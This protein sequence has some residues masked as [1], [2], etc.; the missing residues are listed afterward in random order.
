MKDIY[1]RIEYNDSPLPITC[2]HEDKKSSTLRLHYS[3]R[4]KLLCISIS[5]Y[6]TI[7]I[8]IVTVYSKTAEKFS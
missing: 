3:M 4:T 1:S 8:R 6:H 2:V 5:Y 7:Y